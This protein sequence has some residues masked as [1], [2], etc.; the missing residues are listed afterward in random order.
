MNLKILLSAT[1]AAALAAGAAHAQLGTAAPLPSEDMTSNQASPADPK[2]AQTGVPSVD[3]TRP[4][5]ADAGRT[6]LP[7]GQ[8]SGGAATSATATGADASADAHAGHMASP[9]GTEADASA[10]TG[11]AGDTAATSGAATGAAADTSATLS[12]NV[13]ANEPVPDTAENRSKYR[14]LSAAGRAT[15]ARGN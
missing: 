5:G 4:T 14:P 12:T 2:E 10:R 7:D 1:A 8:V 9:S 13:V 15:A 6:T 3:S 11:T